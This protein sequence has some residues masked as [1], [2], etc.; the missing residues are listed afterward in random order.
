MASIKK[1]K[2]VVRCRWCGAASS[3]V[4]V[5]ND[6]EYCMACYGNFTDPSLKLKR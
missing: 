2:E 6:K 5:E 3:L 1:K 4:F